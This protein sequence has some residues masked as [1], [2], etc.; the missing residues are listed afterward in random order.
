MNRAAKCE[1]PTL[2]ADSDDKHTDPIPQY[3]GENGNMP[4]HGAIRIPRPSAFI[5]RYNRQSERQYAAVT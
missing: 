5:G 2:V 1:K 4:R 3:A